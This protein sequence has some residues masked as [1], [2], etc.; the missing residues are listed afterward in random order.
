LL[1]TRGPERLRAIYRSGG[2]FQG[3]YGQSLQ[4]LEPLWHAFLEKQPVDQREQAR[5]RDRFRRPAIFGKVCA[6]ELAARVQEA[7]GR[8][9]S[10]PEKAIDLLRSVCQDDPHEPSYRLDLADALA[11]AGLTDR[12]IGEASAVERDA[13][14]TDPLRSRAAQITASALYHAGRFDE[15]RAAVQRGLAFATEDAEQRTGLARMRA[16]ED[17]T[18]R[19]TLARVLFGDTPLRGVEA[20]LVVFLLD[21]FATAHPDEAL[22][23]YLLGRQIAYRDPKLSLE[24][25]E[26]ACPL[27]GG[28]ARAKPLAPVFIKECHHLVADAAFRAEDL[29]RAKLALERLRTDA[30]SLADQLRAEDLLERVEWENAR[31]ARYRRGPSP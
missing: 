12:A 8:L 22:G 9:Y 1:V 5:A 7:R 24:L 11:A 13:S 25:L 6:R 21:R 20:G 26:S 19:S 30:T 14:M 23:P 3:V 18:A 2:D 28:A 17:E 15:S 4:A 10:V 16:L 27:A 31:L 29:T